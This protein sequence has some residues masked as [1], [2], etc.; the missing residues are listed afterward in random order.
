MRPK[1]HPVLYLMLTPAPF[2]HRFLVPPV[3][4][5]ILKR[6]PAKF[7]EDGHEASLR[8]RGP[9]SLLHYFTKA[10]SRSCHL[11]A[12]SF[13]S[14]SLLTM[15]TYDMSDSVYPD[16]DE[17]STVAPFTSSDYP[18][19]Q[20]EQPTK[21][22]RKAWGQPIPDFKVV[23]PPRKRAKT[24]EEKEQR[25]NERVIRNRKAA[26]KSRQRQK[27][28][29]AEL[30]I[31]TTHMEAELAQLRVK[32]AYF[33]TKYGAVQD[34]DMPPLTANLN[35]F[36][37]SSSSARVQSASPSPR[38]PFSSEDHVLQD[39]LPA[40]S[41]AFT[42][43]SHLS[44]GDT[45]SYTTTP[46]PAISMDSPRPSISSNHSPALAPTLFHTP[47]QF[48]FHDLGHHDPPPAYANLGEVSD[49]AQ[50]SAAVLCEGQQCQLETSTTLAQQESA[51]HFNIRLLLVNLTILMSIYET[52]STSM[53]LPMC[54]I[55]RTLGE[56]LSTISLTED[57]MDR[58]FPLIH[59]LIT[60]P[61]S[62][63]T[64]PIF[65]MKLLSRLLACSPSLA[66]L[67]EAATDKVLQ[68]LVDDEAILNG[69]EGRQQWAS[70]LALRWVMHR[71]DREHQRYRLVV[72]GP[73]CNEQPVP[74]VVR[75]I[76]LINQMEG[77]DY[78]AVEKSLWRWRSGDLTSAA[79]PD[80]H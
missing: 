44:P 16:L 19:P 74:E 57:W 29:V 1:G 13:E 75:Q 41:F 39:S 17:S 20:S 7:P 24:Q 2:F 70:L 63:M 31:K 27:A 76:G 56:S 54:Q 71:L 72:D 3:T 14:L 77:V 36:P 30:E 45:S 68:R 80:V 78:R 47:D 26:D 28:A 34:T 37:Q 15:T 35:T 61:T 25:K 60:T 48:S 18:S 5:S 64:R 23:L 10:A 69:P 55:F 79:A 42:T 40:G 9:F 22:K 4:T 38:E 52:F 46:G 43:M 6:P 51:N 73:R 59:S 8:I 66:R 65:R 12:N 67:L 49:L 11:G 21:K 33:E 32:V 58:H 53:L 50:Y 62:R